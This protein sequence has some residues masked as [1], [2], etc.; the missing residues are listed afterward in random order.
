MLPVSEALG[1][2]EKTG[3]SPPIRIC[4]SEIP[5]DVFDV[6]VGCQKG[7]AALEKEMPGP[8]GS[9]AGRW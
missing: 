1:E 3:E 5:G 9:W 8:T 6:E 2:G 4:L 7:S